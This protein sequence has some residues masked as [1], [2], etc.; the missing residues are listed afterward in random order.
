MP[1]LRVE[2]VESI[3]HIPA[4]VWN[5]LCGDRPFVDHRWLRMVER[6]LSDHQARY[7]L[8]HGDGQLA[9]AAVCG[10]ER[11]FEHPALQRRAGWVLNRFPYLRCSIPIALETGLIVGDGQVLE[12]LAAVRRLARQERALLTTFAHLTPDSPAWPTLRGGGC[13][14]LSRWWSTALPIRWA[15]FDEYLASRSTADRKEIGR[16]RRR[17]ARDG[18]SVDHGPLRTQDAPHL[19]AL[20]DNVLARHQAPDPY[21]R[22]FLQ[23][24]STILEGDLH[25][26]QARQAGEPVG[27]AVL[28][29]S[30]GELMAKWAGMDYQKTHNSAAYHALLIECINLAVELG[31]QRLRLGATAYSTKQ[32]FGAVP[33]ERLNAVALPSSLA[34]VLPA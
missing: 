27:C 7:V 24:A 19:R 15:S 22:D 16:L 3:D 14:Q 23:S 17:A 18:I 9:A 21:A 25:V 2:V 29:K 12:L 26:V 20:I 28:V 33:E 32:Q 11:R 5:V 8:L 4:A 1:E 10:L 6:V 34:G 31:V 13:R 30:Q